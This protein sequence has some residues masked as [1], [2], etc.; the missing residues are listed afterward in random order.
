MGT[1]LEEDI[2]NA[3]R[4]YHE[5]TLICDTTL[6]THDQTRSDSYNECQMSP[7]RGPSSY[8]FEQ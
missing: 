4:P 3:L 8:T 7:Q 1:I 6:S 2:I 5:E